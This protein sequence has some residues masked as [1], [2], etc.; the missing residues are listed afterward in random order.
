[1]ILNVER[2]EFLALLAAGKVYRSDGGR[3]I[4][5]LH[6]GNNRRC[7]ARLREFTEHMPVLAVLH[8]R[9]YELTAEGQKLREEA[10]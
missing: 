5:E 1:V 7:E 9:Y 10:S 4:V 6:P 2:R 3:D 8:G